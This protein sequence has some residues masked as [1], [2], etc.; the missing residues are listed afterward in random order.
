MRISYE[1][2]KSAVVSVLLLLLGAFFLTKGFGTFYRYQHASA[3]S[4]LNQSSCREGRYVS[5]EIESCLVKKMAGSERY[6]GESGVM[7]TG[8]KEYR[9]YT[10]PVSDGRYIRIMVRNKETKRA[11]QSLIKEERETVSFTGVLVVPSWEMSLRWYEDIPGFHTEELIQEYV[12]QEI[13]LAGSKNRM[14]IGG[15]LLFLASLLYWQSG[16]IEKR[17]LE[18][19][20]YDKIERYY[21]DS[22]N[23]ENELELERGRMRLYRERKKALMRWCAAS[24]GCLIL[25]IY[26]VAISYFYEG[27]LVGILIILFALK[28]ILQ[29]FIHSDLTIA[30]KIART[31]E[32][33]TLHDEIED[34]ELR[35]AILEDLLKKE[36]EALFHKKHFRIGSGL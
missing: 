30:V 31:F 9:F 29:G 27:K 32:K 35:I 22:Y 6:E 13:D 15:I 1:I 18:P 21:A 14:I 5:G 12:L 2:P 36:D 34:C 11:L 19:E 4:D 28:G 33:R 10:I 17:I 20:R 3:L 26:I 8:G 24:A 7:L 23:K 16:G 25:G